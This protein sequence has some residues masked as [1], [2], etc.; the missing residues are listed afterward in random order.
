MYGALSLASFAVS[1]GSRVN[2]TYLVFYSN[3]LCHDIARL[4]LL[5]MNVLNLLKLVNTS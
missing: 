2:D 4:S 3:A 5:A 1:A